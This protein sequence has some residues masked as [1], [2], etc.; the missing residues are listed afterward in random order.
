MSSWT[1]GRSFS[2][3]GF[4]ANQHNVA[5]PNIT[6]QK[7]GVGD[8]FGNI[9]NVIVLFLFFISVFYAKLFYSTLSRVTVTK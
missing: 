6:W 3:P 8:L 4:T 1:K 7:N 2:C 9:L 5:F